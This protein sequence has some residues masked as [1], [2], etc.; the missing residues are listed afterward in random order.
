M[1]VVSAVLLGLAV[2][3]AVL[4][5]AQ[6]LAWS[7]GP[8]L[9]AL[10]LAMVFQL[11]WRSGETNWMVGLP[12]GLAALWIW[13]RCVQSP[14]LDGALADALLV[15]A[16]V[17]GAWVASG[18]RAHHAAIR[19]L[20]GVLAVV[21]LGN[22]IMALIQWNHPEFIWPYSVRSS[23]TPSGFFGHYNYYSNFTLGV[24]L[25]V[26]ARLFYSRDPLVLK[27]L[28]AAVFLLGCLT[29]ILSGS[30]GGPVALGVGAVIFLLTSG[31]V[32]WRKQ[33]R[34]SGIILVATPLLLIG[35]AIGGWWMLK[36]AQNARFSGSGN[37]IVRIADNAPRLQWIELSMSI[38]GEQPITGV[39]SRGFASKYPA[40]WDPEAFGR[41]STYEEFVHNEIVQLTTEYGVIGLALVLL[42]LGAAAWRGLAVL[43]LGSDTDEGD[44]DAVAV[45]LLAAGAAMLF[46]SN[47]SFVFHLL[48]STL[49]LG[50]MLGLA[51]P[52]RTQSAKTPGSV[53]GIKLLAGVVTLA[54]ILYFG[55]L[56]T[57]TLQK[58]W[59]TLY[60]SPRLMDTDPE[61]AMEALDDASKWWPG[62][63]LIDEK[64]RLARTYAIQS[65][66]STEHAT[67]WNYV[68]AEAFTQASQYHPFHPG[69]QVNKAN[70]LSD[71]G[72]NEQ[73]EEAFQRATKL[74]GGLEAGFQA[75]FFHAQ[76]LYRLWYERWT[77]ERRAAEALHEFLRA[78]KILESAENDVIWHH[79]E[80]KALGKKLDS[81]IEFLEGAR[82]QPKPPSAEGSK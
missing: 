50:I 73:A 41:S 33:S 37:D 21:A 51:I 77:K 74:Q 82:V 57:L 38:A 76:H 28:Y 9:V 22:E 71:L 18:F 4:Y 12:L 5:G 79:A 64:A 58:I 81:T 56:S 48:P 31:I 63:R 36:Q 19:W 68:A 78:R 11:R 70:T 55:V 53:P 16:V 46:Q 75:K 13:L 30:R 35:V 39:G 10:A 42:T 65:G 26:L 20:F 66:R 2:M 7:W 80:L 3:L 47:V 17:G 1:K 67:E 43:C 62:Y 27:G 34:W 32:T 49:L 6:P 14:V 25:L 8:A 61:A 72:E 40:H 44:N 23:E 52:L 29:I 54:P 45:G 24:S 69:I 59:S 15:L 60:A